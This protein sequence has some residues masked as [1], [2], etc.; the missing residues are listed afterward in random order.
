MKR[1]TTLRSMGVEE[2]FDC[3]VSNTN[4][5]DTNNSIYNNYNRTESRDREDLSQGSLK[6]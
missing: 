1:D 2:E 3:K 4:N 5:N 6:I